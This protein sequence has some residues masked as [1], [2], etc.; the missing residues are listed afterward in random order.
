MESNFIY[1]DY[2]STTPVDNRVLEVML[3][4][5]N[6]M[7]ANPDSPHLFGLSVRDAV[8]GAT[9]DLADMLGSSPHNILYTSGATEAINL[10]IK[11]LLPSERKHVVTVATEHRAVLETCSFLENMGYRVTY[12]PVDAQGMVNLALLADSVTEDTLLVCVML[13][14]N[15]TGVIHPIKE[16]CRIVHQKGAWMLSD[17][18]QAIGKLPINVMDMEVDFLAFSAHK[19]YGPKGIGGLYLSG[20]AKKALSPL[21][22][23]GGQQEGQRSGTLNVPGIIGMGKAATIAV[24]EM[25]SDNE[26]ITGLR[27]KLET[28]LLAIGGTFRNGHSEKRLGNTTNI[29]FRGVSSEQLIMGLGTVSVSSGS[30]CSSTI[31]R[32]SHVLKA[33]GLSDPDGLSALRFSLGRFTTEDEIERTVEKM[34]AVVAR[35]RTRPH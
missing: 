18:T 5:F 11:G 13:A 35:L 20:R 30:A 27:D 25:S 34:K 8:E 15:E 28:E 17:A 9:E 12:L 6:T 7:H 26:R 4:Y 10:A 14:N 31:N 16:I 3:P 33:M 32:P 2:N 29:G 23:G 22:H 1:L 19:F 21:I 24:S